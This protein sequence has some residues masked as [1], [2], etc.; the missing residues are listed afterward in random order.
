MVPRKLLQRICLKSIFDLIK[1]EYQDV[2]HQTSSFP[3]ISAMCIGHSQ[4]Y[5]GHALS[6]RPHR[7]QRI[8]SLSQLGYTATPTFASEVTPSLSRAMRNENYYEIMCGN[9]RH[10]ARLLLYE[11][12]NQRLELIVDHIN[13]DNDPRPRDQRPKASDVLLGFWTRTLRLDLGLLW[14]LHFNMVT[15]EGMR[16][17]RASVYET[18]GSS[19]DSQPLTIRTRCEI[20]SP[21]HQALRIVKSSKFGKLT[22]AMMENYEE[23]MRLGIHVETYEYIPGYTSSRIFSFVVTLGSG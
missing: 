11:D 4:S 10:I 13:L 19:S 2:V 8:H 3:T 16:N 7:K 20:G 9:Q 5:D 22:T 21:E 15:E 12:H 23:A 6:S 1:S 14:R 17:D 18:M